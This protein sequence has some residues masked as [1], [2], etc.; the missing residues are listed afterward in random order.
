MFKNRYPLIEEVF[1]CLSASELFE[2]IKDKPY[3]FF[4]DSGMD[5]QRLGRYSFLGS[6]PFLVMSSRGSEI[7]LI[8]GQEHEVQ[9]GNPFDALDKL[10]EA[11]KLD[12]CPGACAF[13]GWGGGLF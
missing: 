7:N 11:Y 2:L 4:L 1:T 10:L 6:E 5:P 3:S 12:H 13:L 8:R 9:Y